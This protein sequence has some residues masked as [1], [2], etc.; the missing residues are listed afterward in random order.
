M[1]RLSR[2]FQRYGDG[3]Q[4]QT[5][6]DRLALGGLNDRLGAMTVNVTFAYHPLSTKA[7]IEL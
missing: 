4:E 6:T 1:V 2:P 7:I 5:M 3:I